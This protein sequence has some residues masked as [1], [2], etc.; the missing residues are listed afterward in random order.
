MGDTS[1]NKADGEAPVV[2][3]CIHKVCKA[4]SE[5]GGDDEKGKEASASVRSLEAKEKN[6]QREGGTGEQVSSEGLPRCQP[7]HQGDGL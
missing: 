5:K 3:C 6:P 2:G 1:T 7:H 4:E